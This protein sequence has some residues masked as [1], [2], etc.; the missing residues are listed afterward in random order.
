[1]EEF[2]C[3]LSFICFYGYIHMLQLAVIPPIPWLLHAKY[4]GHYWMR[5]QFCEMCSCTVRCRFILYWSEEF[6]VFLLA[7]D[8]LFL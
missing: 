4:F 5:W 6:P 3:K 1:M 7:F 8:G 2:L